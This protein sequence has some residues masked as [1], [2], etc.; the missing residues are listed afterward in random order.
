VRAERALER[1]QGIWMLEQQFEIDDHVKD[2]DKV[3]L[4]TQMTGTT[5]IAF[6]S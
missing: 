3:F 2:S 4:S 5:T 6:L 1:Q